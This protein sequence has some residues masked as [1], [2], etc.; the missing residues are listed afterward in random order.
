MLGYSDSNK[1]GGFL[2]SNWELYK[3][4]IALVEVFAPT[5]VRLRFFHGRGGTRRPRRRAELRGHPGATARARCRARSGITEQG[6]VIAAKY[7]NPELGRR[8]LEALVAATLEATPARR[9]ARRRRAAG[10]SSTPWTSSR[11]RRS[12][13]YRGLVYETPGLRRVLPRVH[14][15]RRDRRRSTSAAG[16]PRA[17]ASERIEDL[18]AIPWVFSWAQCRADAAR[19][20]RLR[21]R[22]R[23][24]LD[25]R[26]RRGWRALRAHD[27][28]TG[29]SSARCCRTWTWCS[30]RPTSPSP[31]RYAELVPDDAA[32]RRHLRRI[33][34]EMRADRRRAA[35]RSPGSAACSRTTR[36]WP[37]RI[38]NRFP[39]LD[40]LNHLQ[41]E[42]LQRS[43]RRR[44]RSDDL[45]RR[46]STS[47][48]TGSPPGCATAGE[49]LMSTALIPAARS[50]GKG[51]QECAL[52]ARI[53]T[54]EETL[55]RDRTQSPGSPS[56]AFG[57]PGMTPSRSAGLRP[58]L[59]GVG[60]CGPEARAPAPP[61]PRAFRLALF[62]GEAA[63]L[64]ARGP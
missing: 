39:Y 31:S 54:L 23:A 56:R 17:S 28:A 22:G 44:R 38:R 41:V 5:G 43:P 15:D 61:G 55:V 35:R 45:V 37:A 33:A 9:R 7:A 58:A 50:A 13:A 42:L 59:R 64:K 18:R 60:R 36:C 30:P 52:A 47:R 48:S 14:A 25:A 1:D 49:T 46:A 2:T 34:P 24:W 62:G 29:R 26:R 19:L 51:I 53:A 20:V 12:R 16:R 21:H 11:P 63:S 6:E 27:A 40:P 3:A 32:A 8:N 4:E 10:R 57:A